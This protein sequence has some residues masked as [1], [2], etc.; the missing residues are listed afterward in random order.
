MGSKISDLLQRGRYAGNPASSGANTIVT[1][2]SGKK[3]VVTSYFLQSSGTVN[4]TFQSSTGSVAITGTHYE[5]A[6]TGVSASYNEEFKTMSR[7]EVAYDDLIETREFLIKTIN[8]TLTDIEREF[9]VSLKNGEPKWELLNPSSIE[10]LPGVQW[11]LINIKKMNATK[12]EKQLEN[13]KKVL[14]P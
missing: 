3:I 9:L 10:H 2:V 11:K 13:L 6:N 5:V 4:A 7:I 12:R 1:G 14:Y 8:Q